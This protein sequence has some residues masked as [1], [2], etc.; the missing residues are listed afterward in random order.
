MSLEAI[1]C[2]LHA[3]NQGSVSLRCA[4]QS[5][6]LRFFRSVTFALTFFH[7][8]PS[9]FASIPRRFIYVRYNIQSILLYNELLLPNFVPH[10]RLGNS[11]SLAFI[12]IKDVYSEGILSSLHKKDIPRTLLF[13][14]T[15]QQSFYGSL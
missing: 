7:A 14:H 10:Y 6:T 13:L 3:N 15:I 1:D 11:L 5:R 2:V 12:L 9:A 4:Y 8:F